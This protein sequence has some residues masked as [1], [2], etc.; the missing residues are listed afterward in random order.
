MECAGSK[1]A[2]FY[3]YEERLAVQMG[4][5]RPTKIRSTEESDLN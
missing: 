2:Y 1:E 3:H 4:V 5:K